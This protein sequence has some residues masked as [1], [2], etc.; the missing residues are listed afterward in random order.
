MSKLKNI[1][2]IISLS[3]F[4]PFA[5]NAS[6][7]LEGISD[8]VPFIVG[9]A[10][11]FP[12]D[13]DLVQLGIYDPAFYTELS[14]HAQKRHT[15]DKS[16]TVLVQMGSVNPLTMREASPLNVLNDKAFEV[17]EKYHQQEVTYLCYGRKTDPSYRK[18]LQCSFLTGSGDVAT[19]LLRQG[20]AKYNQDEFNQW[21]HDEYIE[22]ESL[23]K[24]Q[25]IGV[26]ESKPLAIFN[27]I[28]TLISE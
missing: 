14:Q 28:K 25:Q 2:A 8:D 13:S 24:D 12:L 9:K 15:N 27:G 4:I 21:Q 3:L 7:Y 5:A 10:L 17:V 23:A 19:D 22:N 11:F 6:S 18:L 20:M 1:S 26:W 16:Q